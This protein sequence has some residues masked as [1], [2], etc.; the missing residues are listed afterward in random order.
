MDITQMLYR[1]PDIEG[2]VSRL[3]KEI[4]VIIE[5]KYQ[6]KITSDISG[7]PT[8]PHRNDYDICK[9][10][11]VCDEQ[12]KEKLQRIEELLNTKKFVDYVYDQLTQTEKDIVRLRYFLSYPWPQVSRE[13]CISIKQL[14]RRSSQIKEKMRQLHIK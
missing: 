1:Y 7:S 5:D 3:R 4:A 8:K 14:Y 9:A 11:I 10:I 6:M 12:I 2:E 13:V